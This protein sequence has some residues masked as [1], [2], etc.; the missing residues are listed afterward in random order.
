MRARAHFPFRLLALSVLVVGA[1][2]M[3]RLGASAAASSGDMPPLPLAATVQPKIAQPS[4]VSSRAATQLDPATVPAELPGPCDPHYGTLDR[5]QLP[6]QARA[7]ASQSVI[8]GTVEAIG[9][10]QWN[11]LGAKPPEAKLANG[12][13]VMRLFR[14]TALTTLAG[15]D[16]A[17]DV[18]WVP[19][20]T[21]GC[22]TFTIAGYDIEVGREYIFF[23]AANGAHAGPAGTLEAGEIWPVVGGVVETPTEGKI[24]ISQFQTLIESR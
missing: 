23:L 21:I 3:L 19:G 7:A 8:R 12:L 15:E 13:D 17:A 18:F 20:G 14:V 6:V 5:I 10:A 22:V 11:T 1:A 16:A 2:A 24:S 9:Q 4:P